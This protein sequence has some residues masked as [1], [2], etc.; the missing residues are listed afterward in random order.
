MNV[1]SK[2]TTEFFKAINSDLSK[3][4]QAIRTEADRHYYRTVKAAKARCAAIEKERLAAQTA[5][6]RR[7]MGRETARYE[8]AAKKNI[9][10]KRLKIAE[11]V[12]KKTSEKLI[13]FTKSDDYAAFLAKSAAEIS[14]VLDAGDIVFYMRPVDIGFSSAI[15]N[16]CPDCRIE[17]DESIIIGGL[18]ASSQT[19]RLA[20][21]DTLDTR[22]EQQKDCYFEMFDSFT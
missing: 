5:K 12:F 2:D 22:L 9:Y 18:K 19:E 21:D 1:K 16:S 15:R 14:K 3:Q 13:D 6:L 10:D 20:A 11:N 7:V 17:Q 8:N 4:V